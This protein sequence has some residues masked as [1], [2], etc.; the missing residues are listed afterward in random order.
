MPIQAGP[1]EPSL[2]ALGRSPFVASVVGPFHGE[3]IQSSF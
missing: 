1:F 3:S 2:R